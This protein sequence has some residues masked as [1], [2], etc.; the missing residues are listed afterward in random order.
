MRSTNSFEMYLQV[1]IYICFWLEKHDF[2]IQ[3]PMEARKQKLADA[4]KLQQ[5]LRDVEDEE[6][7]IREKEPIASST[8][9]GWW[10]INCISVWNKFMWHVVLIPLLHRSYIIRM[11]IFFC[12]LYWNITNVNEFLIYYRSRSYWRSKL[13]EEAPSF[14]GRNCWTWI[15]NQK[16]LYPWQQNDWRWTFCQWRDPT[17]DWR[18]PR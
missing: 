18:A 7:W 12:A 15:S 9:R 13:D 1:H 5:F 17:E 11:K 16:C 14:A 10:W 4:L 3:D 6:D 8:N 2:V